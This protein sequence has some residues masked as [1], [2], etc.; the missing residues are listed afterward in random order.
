MYLHRGGSIV[1]FVDAVAA[2]SSKNSSK[3]FQA[4]REEVCPRGRGDRVIVVTLVG[5]NCAGVEKHLHYHA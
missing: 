5:P 2:A 1:D 3:D 4:H